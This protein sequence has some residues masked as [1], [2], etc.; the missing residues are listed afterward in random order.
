MLDLGVTHFIECGPGKV[1]SGLIRK[2]DRDATVLSV[3]DEETL[4]AAIE[5]SKGW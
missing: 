5:A 1:L 3:Y 4:Q 2:I